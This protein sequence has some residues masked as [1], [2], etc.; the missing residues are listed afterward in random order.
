MFAAMRSFDSIKALRFSVAMAGVALVALALT[1]CKGLPTKGERTAWEDLK[2]VGESY[3]P[4][5]ERPTLPT[6]QTNAPLSNFLAFAVLNQPQVEA[7]YFD[8]AASIERI[9][10][11]RSLPDPRLTFESDIADAVMSLV[12]GLMM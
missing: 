4:R 7:A 12:P 6:L 2:T 1:G 5:N 3:R 11:E 8:W 10:R 9:T